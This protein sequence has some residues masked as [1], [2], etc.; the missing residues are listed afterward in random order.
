MT[1]RQD[2]IREAFAKFESTLRLCRWAAIE[3]ALADANL[4]ELT[5]GERDEVD[6]AAACGLAPFDKAPQGPS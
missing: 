4:A 6:L 3:S 1:D 2:V 5:S